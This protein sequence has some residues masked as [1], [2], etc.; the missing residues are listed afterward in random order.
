MMEGYGVDLLASTRQ[1]PT[2]KF[3]E[4]SEILDTIILMCF[5]F[6]AQQVASR[7]GSYGNERVR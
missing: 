1:N 4:I 6:C 7:V 5:N 3:T 2:G